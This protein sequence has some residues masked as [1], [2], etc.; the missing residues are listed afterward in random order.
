MNRNES[1]A[2]RGGVRMLLRGEG[3]AVFATASGLYFVGGGV[4]WVYALLLFVPD[5]SFIGYSAG[6]RLGAAL[7]NAAH[8]YI[9]PLA[10]GT[11]GLMLDIDWMQHVALIHLAHIGLDRSLGYGLKYADG[12]QHTHFGRLGRG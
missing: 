11:A 7:Y 2:V 12:F 1:G 9:L 4:W 5:L 10:M 6:N 8:T 3:L